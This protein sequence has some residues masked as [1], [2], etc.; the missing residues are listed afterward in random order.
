MS[1]KEKQYKTMHYIREQDAH[2]KMV[3]LKE[4][5]SALG[6]TS[7]SAWS[8]FNTLENRG[9]I[10]KIAPNDYEITAKGNK[11]IK[12]FES[13]QMTAK[14]IKTKKGATPIKQKQPKL[15]IKGNKIVITIEIL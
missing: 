8:R 9:F 13:S 15:E 14:R 12:I 4:A 7:E 6:I 2:G 3:Y 10:K 1:N 11:F 5:G